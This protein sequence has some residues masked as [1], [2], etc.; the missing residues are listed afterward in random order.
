MVALVHALPTGEQAGPA[1]ALDV[2]GDESLLTAESAR[3]YGDRYGDDDDNT[4]YGDYDG[5]RESE[6][7]HGYV[8]QK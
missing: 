5:D 3:D 2:S 8:L 7:Y 1:V 4:R 6:E